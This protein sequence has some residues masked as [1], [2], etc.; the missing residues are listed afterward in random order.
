[1]ENCG[2]VN[3]PER[4]RR[5][6]SQ[7]WK[8]VF[9]NSAREVEIET[10]SKKKPKRKLVTVWKSGCGGGEAGGFVV[11]SFQANKISASLSNAPPRRA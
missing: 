5:R 3:K 2:E 9:S 11:G 1:M 4:A 6:G 8:Q 10:Q 7:D